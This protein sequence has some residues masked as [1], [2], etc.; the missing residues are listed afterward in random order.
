[1][2]RKSI[3]VLGVLSTIFS[4]VAF[5][6]NFTAPGLRSDLV[7]PPRHNVNLRV[8]LTGHLPLNLL[9]VLDTFGVKADEQSQI[10]SHEEE[11]AVNLDC[12]NC[13]VNFRNS[14]VEISSP[15][16]D[17]VKGKNN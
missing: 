3:S 11:T 2:V 17:I 16:N 7:T 9:E 13:I 14:N 5:G 12:F 8:P 10:F 4:E 1:M 6:A 15:E